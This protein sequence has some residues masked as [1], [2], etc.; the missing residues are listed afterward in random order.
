VVNVALPVLQR[1]I[2]A[3]FAQAQWVIEAYTLLLSALTLVG[4][5]A[6]DIYGR[7]R[8]F[9]LGILIFALASAGCGF[10]INPDMLIAARVL[11]GIG[12]ALMVPGSLALLAAHFPP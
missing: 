7:R 10:A 12:G 4:G 11:Q 2:G 3:S 9:S 6:G 8:V 1:S 5:A